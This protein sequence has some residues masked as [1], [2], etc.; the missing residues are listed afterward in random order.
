MFTILEHKGKT[1]NLKIAYIGD[2]N[3]V[4]N[5]W[6][7]ISTKFPIHLSLGIPEGYE[8]DK[9]IFERAVTSDVSNIQIYRDKFSAVKD[10]DVIYTDVW[11]SMGQEDE[12]EKRKIDFK[13]FQ[14]NDELLKTAKSDCIV[15]HCLPAH[16]GEEI[17]DEVIDSEHSVVFDEAE[18]R[19]HA[20]KAIIIKLLTYFL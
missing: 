8:P 18:N 9:D 10:A 6:L 15:M 11:T 7:N 1:D 2:G 12:A 4:V 3:N 16:R 14:V 17:T 5:S 20:Q 13:D 19:L